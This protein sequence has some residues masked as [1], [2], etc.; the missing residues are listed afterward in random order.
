M[1]GSWKLL[2]EKKRE[3]K[4]E[5]QKP[6][7]AE[8]S[9]QL[10]WE[11]CRKRS[12]KGG[13]PTPTAECKS[14]FKYSITQIFAFGLQKLMLTTH[15]K[16]REGQQAPELSE[17]HF[18]FC[19]KPLHPRLPPTLVAPGRVWMLCSVVNS[20]WAGLF[21]W[22]LWCCAPEPGLLWSKPEGHCQGEVEE[23]CN[24]SVA[25]LVG[26]IKCLDKNVQ[27]VSVTWANSCLP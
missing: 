24:A 26:L 18:W 16:P 22:Y 25:P 4:T 9:L 23:G 6:G 2:E 10:L 27:S 1:E 5:G 15:S 13:N 20:V 8:S 21:W 14:M 3:W 12:Q 19:C 7:P 17:H 11:L